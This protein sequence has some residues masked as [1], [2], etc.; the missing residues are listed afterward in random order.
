MN[1]CIVEDDVMRD[2]GIVFIRG[3]IRGRHEVLRW[4]VKSAELVG[5]RKAEEMVGNGGGSSLVKLEIERGTNDAFRPW[6][7]RLAGY[8]LR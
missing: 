2:N 7:T 8:R 6:R 4:G 1:D 3:R 5:S